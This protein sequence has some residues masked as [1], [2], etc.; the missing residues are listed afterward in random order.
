MQVRYQAALR[1]D[2]TAN[3]TGGSRGV[4]RG[5]CQANRW[6]RDRGNDAAAASLRQRLDQRED[7]ALGIGE[8]R[9]LGTA[10]GDDTAWAPLAWHVE[11]RE[12]NSAPRE[13]RDFALDVVDLEERLARARCAGV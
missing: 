3:Y 12:R 9:D 2:R 6:R 13:I 11:M 1:P 5:P 8:P 7:V 10:G 4:R